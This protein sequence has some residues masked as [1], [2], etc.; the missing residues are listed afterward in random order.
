MRARRVVTLLIIAS[1]VFGIY[2]WG[3]YGQLRT[4]FNRQDQFVPTRFYSDVTRISPPQSRA[5]IEERLKS[6]LYNF[7]A[8]GNQITFNLHPV[9]YPVYLIPETHPILNAG[10]LQLQPITLNF[11]GIRPESLLQSIE[12]GSQEIPDLYLEPEIVATLSKSGDSGKKQIRA[13]LGFANIPAN[14]WRAVIAIEDQHFM[15]HGGLD[16]RGI[17]RAIWVNLKTRSFAQGGSTITQQ[18]VKNLMARRGKNLFSKVNELF[19]S[20]L[21]ESAFD[22]EKILERYLNEVYLGQIG[23]LEVHGVAEGARHFFGKDV[24]EL[25]LAEIALM[26]G[27]IR[28]PGYYSPYRYK[29]RALERQRLVLKK[30]VETGQIAQGEADQALQLPVRLAPPQTTTNKAPYFT[31]FVKAELIRQLNGRI[32]EE[33]LSEAGLRVYTTLDLSLNHAAQ[34]ALSQGLAGLEAKLTGGK[35]QDRLEGALACVDHTNGF[36]RALIGGRNYAESNFNRILN[37]KRQV[38]STFKPIVYLSAL[39][40]GRDK[41][42]VPYGPGHPVEDSPW[43]LIYDRGKQKWAPKNYEKEYKGWTSY[44]HALAHSINTA[45]AKIGW[46][47]GIDSVIKTARAMGIESDLPEVPS[48][49][50]GVAELSPI[51]LLKTYSTFANHGLQDN[52]TVIRAITEDNGNAYARFVYHPKQVF[53]AGAVDLLT[54]MLQSVFSEGTAKE[55][56]KMGFD[57]PAAGKTGTTSNYRDAWFA[58]YTPQLT[59]VVWVGTDHANGKTTAENKN[60]RLTGATSAL[61]IWVS[62]MKTALDGEPPLT[63]RFS[64]DVLDVT[65]DQKTGQRASSQC[66]ISQVMTEK[67]LKDFEPEGSSCES[68]WPASVSTVTAN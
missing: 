50:L 60:I 62:F 18:L 66:P 42:G 65:I 56:I 11:T 34:Q 27:L 41:N 5:F 31:D 32:A 9:D 54:E 53:D 25:N 48:L 23:N 64:P 30:M 20:I 43:T 15:E 35:I 36:I 61:P 38:G 14:I 33:E 63:F 29:E 51:E 7:R 17:A 1:S 2:L 22:K 52:L 59:T 67:Y 58:G 8:N 55:A 46:E 45:A 26:A 12:L 19:L 16:P 44:R 24:G 10:D 37:M 68:Q 4:A 3:L 47:V 13:L 21:L 39:Q 28:G 40:K 57:R 49:A 6:L